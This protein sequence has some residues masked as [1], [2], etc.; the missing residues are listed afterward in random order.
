[1]LLE[2]AS[3]LLDISKGHLSLMLKA[4]IVPNAIETLALP[5]I[6]YFTVELYRQTR[7][8]AAEAHGFILGLATLLLLLLHMFLPF[9]TVGKHE[10]WAGT[11]I[12]SSTTVMVVSTG[13]LLV[14]L[15]FFGLFV[16]GS[17]IFG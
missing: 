7:T 13:I 15:F 9:S 5:I 12:V 10:A 11:M 14:S 4:P 3:N 16:L 17:F 8:G 1:M 6:M 2:T